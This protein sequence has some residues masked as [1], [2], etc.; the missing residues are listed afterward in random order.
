MYSL[1]HNT[2]VMRYLSTYEMGLAEETHVHCHVLTSGPVTRQPGI[3]QRTYHLI[4]QV[5][6][7]LGTSN[8]ELFRYTSRESWGT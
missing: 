1:F 8:S 7:K 6:N 3:T 5:S 2:L 4:G